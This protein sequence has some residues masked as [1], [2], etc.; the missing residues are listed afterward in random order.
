MHT[1]SAPD[2]EVGA[3]TPFA[4]E[5]YG[6]GLIHL[7]W[8][9]ADQARFLMFGS[10]EL[11]PVEFPSPLDTPEKYLALKRL[12]RRNRLYVKRTCM[13]A[14]AALDWYTRCIQ[15]QIELPGDLDSKG[16]PKSL[17]TSQFVQE[18]QWPHL[19]TVSDQIPFVSQF[20]HAPRVHLLLQ[21]DLLAEAKAAASD[22]DGR[23][24][25]SLQ[26]FVDFEVYSEFV[27]SLHLVAPDPIFRGI[28]HGLSTKTP[29]QES[30]F[31][32]LRPRMNK[33][34][35][36]LRVI[37]IDRRPMG[38]GG[39]AESQ[40]AS[41]E[42][43]IRHPAG[44]TGEI[45]MIVL[46]QAGSLLS[47][48]KPTGFIQALDINLITPSPQQKIVVPAAGSSPESSYV[49]A[50]AGHTT[51]V[52]AGQPRSP[53]DAIPLL[54]AGHERREMKRLD[55]RYPER[56]FHGDQEAATE[57]VRSLISSAKQRLWIVDPYFTTIE[58]ISFALATS[59]PKLPVLIV[60]SAE[61]MTK[62]DRID[63][64]RT[65]ADFLNAQLLNFSKHGNF[66]IRVLTGAPAVHDRFLVVDD[67]VW[68]S[69]NSLHTIGER[70]GMVVK[71]RNS[72]DI[73]A[74]LTEILNSDRIADWQVW[75]A[76]R[77]SGR[78]AGSGRAKGWAVVGMAL[79]VATFG[80][81]WALKTREKR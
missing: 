60:T 30:S 43:E 64:K 47:R 4:L 81:W 42:I 70:A 57:F 56:W 39:L 80:C 2:V 36:G 21:P 13:S 37:L 25:L 49:R 41:T 63:P 66:T 16:A 20:W 19:V 1:S 61:A 24:W 9:L 23:K 7:A 27:G 35:D 48:T 73:I 10:V 12:G 75:M 14:K 3:Q 62:K 76:N 78:T 52:T 18:P 17:A 38:V 29:G 50:L 54:A 15:G 58:L 11:F 33:T 8:Y 79:S 69:G 28:D 65:A 6:Y 5:D 71:L 67:S 45:E 46:N 51:K 26:M 77:L 34:V 59:S 55:D 44:T 72:A 31:L 68:F 53:K 32:R 74:N 22:P 40:I